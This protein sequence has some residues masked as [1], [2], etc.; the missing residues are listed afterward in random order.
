MQNNFNNQESIE[1]ILNQVRQKKQSGGSNSTG[2]NS[3]EKKFEPVFKP[4]YKENSNINFSTPPAVE[5]Q[6][7]ARP[8]PKGPVFGARPPEPVKEIPIPPPAHNKGHGVVTGLLGN[9]D[10]ASQNKGQQP[11]KDFSYPQT[12][13]EYISQQQQVQPSSDGK[14]HGVIT[15]LLNDLDRPSKPQQH[16]RAVPTTRPAVPPPPT[17][18]TNPTPIVNEVVDVAPKQQIEETPPTP[19]PIAK[20]VVSETFTPPK[21][22]KSTTTFI[23]KERVITKEVNK[24]TFQSL[25]ELENRMSSMEYTDNSDTV[26]SG[27]QGDNLT[28]TGSIRVEALGDERFYEFFSSTVA[29]DKEALKDA[30]KGKKRKRT[31]RN[32]FNTT[33]INTGDVPRSDAFVPPQDEQVIE[34]AVD[35]IDIEDYNDLTDAAGIL[36]DLKRM[37]R[38]AFF[39]LF[40]I[41]LLAGAV[42]Y[43]SIALFFVSPLPSIF[44]GEGGDLAIYYALLGL[45]T[46]TVLVA[47]PTFGRGFTGLFSIPTQ[48]SFVFISI[49]GSAAQI[50][51]LAITDVSAIA[52]EVTIFAPFAMLAYLI[53]ALGRWLQLKGI[54]TNFSIA[55][56]GFDHSA[57][58]LVKNREAVLKLTSGIKEEYPE[59]LLSRPTAL[60]KNFLRQSFSPHES[61]RNGRRYGIIIFLTAVAAALITYY[62]TQGNLVT[63]ISVFAAVSV[64]ASPL[65]SIFVQVLPTVLMNKSASRVGAII[66]GWEAIEGVGKTTA[67]ML[68]SHDIFPPTS[69]R[70]HAIK[71]FNKEQRIDLAILY[72]ASVLTNACSTLRDIFLSMIEGKTEMLFEVESLTNEVGYGF[73]AWVD[74]KRINIGNRD[75]MEKH[76]I[77]LPSMDFESRFS[78]S[79][80]SVIYLAVS[81]NLYCMFL[82]SY[83]ADE[84]IAMTLNILR[85]SEVSLLIRSDDFNVTSELVSQKFEISPDNLKVLNSKE[86]EIAQRYT[87]YMPDSEG[88]MTHFGTFSSFIGGLRAASAAE[89]AE[90]MASVLQAITV[91]ISLMITVILSVTSGL[92]GLHSAIILA[93]QLVWMIITI[94]VI[95]IKRY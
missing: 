42:T 77:P 16:A 13:Q 11:A 73:T 1:D 70:L 41:T 21:K 38:F 40:V 10:H 33:S 71:T 45:L 63:V 14:G 65:A 79:E 69:V 67:V 18:A 51:V 29:M 91:I 44:L 86:D 68:N 6:S 26:P 56:E 15:G 8:K 47:F 87:N 55:S 28:R 7:T 94:I 83:V 9:L 34:E 81:G 20:P 3:D 60:V 12:Q 74:G 46:L 95:M 48:D 22:K 24:P 17:P 4:E 54:T 52:E 75:L 37:T 23:P 90:R 62:L 30:V 61:D 84:D 19:P 27:E 64:I 72:A 25:K 66:P 50:A 93:Y 85:Q 80:R 32:Y 59:L 35:E 53:N 36:Q 31:M 89:S 58:Y 88:I 49:L 78:K 57:A 43:L 39:R 82:V 5:I 92:H 76:N 2:N